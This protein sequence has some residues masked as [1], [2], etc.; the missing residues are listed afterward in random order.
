M[1]TLIDFKLNFPKEK[2]ES[3]FRWKVLN[4]FSLKPQNHFVLLISAKEALYRLKL[5]NEPF[6]DSESI[7]N[8]RLQSYIQYTKNNI[9]IKLINCEAPIEQIHSQIYSQIK[10]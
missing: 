2:V 1:D 4:I 8:I 6:L 5:K 3:W 10:T 9:K 7:L